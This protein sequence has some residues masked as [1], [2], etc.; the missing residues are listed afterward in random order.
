M[1]GSEDRTS[2][3]E[4]EESPLLEDIASEWLVKA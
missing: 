3:C 2:T 1:E 4:A